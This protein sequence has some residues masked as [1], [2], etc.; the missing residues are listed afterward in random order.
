[1]LLGEEV[2]MPHLLFRQGIHHVKHLS[3]GAIDQPPIHIRFHISRAATAGKEV[4]QQQP[5]TGSQHGKQALSQPLG[6][7]LRKVIIETRGIDEVEASERNLAFEKSAY[8]GGH[9]FYAELPYFPFND[10]QT[11]PILV[12][13]HKATEA[14]LSQG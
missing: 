5:A 6:N 2:T 1:M 3:L 14:A 12:S 11:L 7:R 8:R 9:R 13:R 10:G 4:R